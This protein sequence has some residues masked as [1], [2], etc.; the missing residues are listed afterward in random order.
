[1][2]DRMSSELISFGIVCKTCKITGKCSYI[3]ETC[4]HQ[5]HGLCPAP[6]NHD[7]QELYMVLFAFMDVSFY[8]LCRTLMT[9]TGAMAAPV[10][11]ARVAAAVA[12]QR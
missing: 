6:N 3:C 10:A 12:R 11:V 5:N 4:G 8:I 7:F 9:T 1:M 2:C